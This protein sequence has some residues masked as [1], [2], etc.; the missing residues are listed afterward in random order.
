[1]SDNVILFREAV[2][3]SPILKK[4]DV[5]R[6]VKM[7]EFSSHIEAN[8]E[9]HDHLCELEGV[10]GV[11]IN[12]DMMFPADNEEAPGQATYVSVA[13][14]YEDEAWEEMECISI[15]HIHRVVGPD[16]WELRGYE[17]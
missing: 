9:D 10:C 17:A 16:S 15:Y 12:I 8:E 14:P 4:G 2:E 13:I 11:V 1:M 3:L 6:L 7:D 5:V